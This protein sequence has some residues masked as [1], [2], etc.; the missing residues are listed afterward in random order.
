MIK[1]HFKE[2]NQPSVHL[3]RSQLGAIKNSLSRLC[4]TVYT[5]QFQAYV[6]LKC[7]FSTFSSVHVTH[8]GRGESSKCLWSLGV[9]TSH[10]TLCLLLARLMLCSEMSQANV[11]HWNLLVM[12]RAGKS[13]NNLITS[14][15]YPN[16][17][18]SLESPFASSLLKK[19][20]EY[21]DFF[22]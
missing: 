22:F 18:S 14:A 5:R 7:S 11:S 13:V 9:G 12:L 19:I 2:F 1:T 21:I 16:G 6:S 8:S 15:S 17:C 3:P 20:R 10:G 4:Q